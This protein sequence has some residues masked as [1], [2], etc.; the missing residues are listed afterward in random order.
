MLIKIG[1]NAI[2]RTALQ[3]DL[4]EYVVLV[5]LVGMSFVV[6]DDGSQMRKIMFP[7]WL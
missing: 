3:A 5:M 1:G 2:R 4:V 6:D 7:D